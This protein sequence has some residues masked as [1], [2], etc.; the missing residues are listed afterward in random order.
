M[1]DYELILSSIVERGIPTRTTKEL[2]D[3]G[4]NDYYIK[5]ATEEGQLK[6]IS[7][8]NYELVAVSSQKKLTNI[9]L[10]L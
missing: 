9:L 6:K 7:R 2:K 1:I 8:G 3:F 4:L 5:K 10:N